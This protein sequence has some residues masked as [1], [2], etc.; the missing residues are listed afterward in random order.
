MIDDLP[1]R[2]YPGSP[3][4]KAIPISATYPSGPSVR[5]WPLRGYWV[6]MVGVNMVANEIRCGPDIDRHVAAIKEYADAGFD[7]L[8]INP[9]R[10][11]AGR[12]LRRLP[13]R[14]APPRTLKCPTAIAR[15]KR[16]AGGIQRRLGVWARYASCRV[17][18]HRNVGHER[19]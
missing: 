3:A 17:R 4:V 8:Y 14:G 12:V 15:V 1:S 16:R 5:P 18:R 9:D 2:T 10:S 13:E 19:A 11:R 6:N 7:E